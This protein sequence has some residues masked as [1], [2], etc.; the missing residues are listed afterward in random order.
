MSIC[1]LWTTTLHIPQPRGGGGGG[2]RLGT[3]LKPRYDC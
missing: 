2:V 3:D 1:A